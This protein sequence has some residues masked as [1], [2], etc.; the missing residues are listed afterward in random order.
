MESTKYN[1]GNLPP[2]VRKI[3]L[4]NYILENRDDYRASRV[5]A[6]G[7]FEATEKI[8]P[9]VKT[10]GIIWAT[11]NYEVDGK[12]GFF[13]EIPNSVKVLKQIIPRVE[14]SKE[15]QK[16][17]TKQKA[18]VF[19]PSWVANM[20]N[21]MVDDHIFGSKGVFNTEDYESRSWVGTIDPIVFPDEV[22]PDGWIEYV[23]ER[24]LEITCG[25]APYLV[26]RY[27]TVTGDY[28][29][30]RGPNGEWQRI[31]LLDRKLRVVSE[32]CPTEDV[33]LE[34][35][36]IA[37]ENTNGYEWQG[38]N[39]LLARLNMLNTIVDYHAELFDTDLTDEYVLRIAKLIS[40]SIW[41]MDGL[42]GVAPESCS[43]EC[44]PCNKAKKV[45]FHDGIVPVISWHDEEKVPF[46]VI[47]ES[48]LESRVGQ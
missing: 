12:N 9:K 34:A 6:V 15:I 27:D 11:D 37:M 1:L 2:K 35:A 44:G 23:V 29:P 18:E 22:Y 36:Y 7:L 5:S 19:T 13:D 43:P 33:W 40:W 8:K 26:S 4:N 24:R 3:L 10:A 21:N 28:I 25:E 46:E 47:M 30:V 41:Q 45:Y 17:R 20:Q 16:L 14:K 38:D 48:F 42:K 31:G 32:H 39:L